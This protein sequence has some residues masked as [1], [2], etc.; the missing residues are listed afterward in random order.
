MKGPPLTAT[1]AK[2][3]LCRARC[4]YHR[5]VRL[6]ACLLPAAAFS[7]SGLVA[8][9]GGSVAPST[10]V[11]IG[12]RF[13]QVGPGQRS[14]EVRI[15][16]GGCESAPAVTA[17]ETASTIEIIAT[18][19]APPA[20]TNVICP[21]DSLLE[22]ILVPLA[23]PVGGRGVTGPDQESDRGAH[24]ELL[25][26]GPLVP[27]V[28]GLSPPAAVALLRRIGIHPTVRFRRGQQALPRVIA[29][30]PPPGTRMFG[31]SETMKRWARRPIPVG[32][33]AGG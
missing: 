29:Q 25:K 5:W 12:W 33:L 1:A 27:R 3:D 19:E 21:A 11:P 22:R 26:N 24:L 14:L 31:R 23:R 9:G 8:C 2:V 18:V 30:V 17:R 15:G 7:A 4:G 28:V 16:Y 20:S 13:Q 6:V 10:R 32:L